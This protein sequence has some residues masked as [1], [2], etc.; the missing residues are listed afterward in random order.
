M[1][2]PPNQ[3]AGLVFKHAHYN[4]YGVRLGAK[5]MHIFVGDLCCPWPILGNS[6]ASTIRV[7]SSLSLRLK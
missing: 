6:F 7:V 5:E 2:S 1:Q 4:Y 3:A